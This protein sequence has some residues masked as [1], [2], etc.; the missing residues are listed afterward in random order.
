[1]FT[2]QK[3]H[4]GI[5]LRQMIGVALFTALA[6][7]VMILI[8][9]PVGFLTLDLKDAIITLC[10]LCFG[11][12]AALFASA[13][14]PL[15]EFLTVSSTGVY[16]LIMNFIG[17]A[18]FSLTVSLI[19]RYRKNLIGA[20]VGLISGVF[21]MTAAMMIANL[22]VT[23]YYMHATVEAV[24]EMIPTL[25]L[26]FNLVKAIF[27]AATVMLLY[28]PLS[29]ALQKTGF[30]PASDVRYRFN[31]T[32]IAVI[33]VAVALIAVALFVIFRILGGSFRFGM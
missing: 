33:L 4:T 12:L 3:N 11:P 15:L 21:A 19:Y 28:K 16:G 32:T 7:V 27:N 13:V 31:K 23:P 18:T 1:M 30:L 29:L 10:G 26:P 5:H 9:F 17:T 20:I 25:L 2:N 22:I 8:H 14:V 6:Y 24:R